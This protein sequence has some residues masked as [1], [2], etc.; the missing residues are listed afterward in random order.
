MNGAVWIKAKGGHLDHVII[1]NSIVNS[2]HFTDE[3]TEV[4]VERL[5]ELAKQTRPTP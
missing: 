1:R 4:M 3:Q 5:V 2:E